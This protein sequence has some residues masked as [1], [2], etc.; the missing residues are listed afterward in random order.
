V[1]EQTSLTQLLHQELRSGLEEAKQRQGW[2]EMMGWIGGTPSLPRWKGRHH[3]AV[4]QQRPL[5]RL[6]ALLTIRLLLDMPALA[7]SGLLIGTFEVKQT[8]STAHLLWLGSAKWR[9]A[10]GVTLLPNFRQSCGFRDFDFDRCPSNA[11]RHNR[12][13]VIFG[14]QGQGLISS[15]LRYSSIN[16]PGLPGK[17]PS[18]SGYL[19]IHSLLLRSQRVHSQTM[20]GWLFGTQNWMIKILRV[21]PRFGRL[22]IVICMLIATKVTQFAAPQS[23]SVAHAWLVFPLGPLDRA[24]D[25]QFLSP[26]KIGREVTSLVIIVAGVGFPP[27][28]D[29]VTPGAK[30][31]MS[32]S[33][34]DIVR[35]RILRNHVQDDGRAA[36][37]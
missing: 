11:T 20:V 15:S 14:F 10:H 30:R 28:L 23:W 18:A 19:T 4:D 3:C 24:V 6:E 25:C 32:V 29:F 17:T 5:P 2:L 9:R 8:N 26:Q 31:G 7:N 1:E 34:K 13:C 37:R 27:S 36:C 33:I 21:G 22:I 12:T 16:K 35:R